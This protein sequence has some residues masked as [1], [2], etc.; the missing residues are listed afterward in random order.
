MGPTEGSGLPE[1]LLRSLWTLSE[2]A[3]PILLGSP[4]GH[5]ATG[6]SYFPRVPEHLAALDAGARAEHQDP[7]RGAAPHGTP[8]KS[9]KR[10]ANPPRRE[11]LWPLRHRARRGHRQDPAS[12]GSPCCPAE[13]GFKLPKEGRGSRHRIGTSVQKLL[14]R[15]YAAKAPLQPSTAHHR[16]NFSRK[17]LIIESKCLSCCA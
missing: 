11:E 7:I 3:P 9:W 14:H 10:T 12:A 5:R 2:Q 13:P 15:M 1:R 4:S 17:I 8:R 16:S 6:S